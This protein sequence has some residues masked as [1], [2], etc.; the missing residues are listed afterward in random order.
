MAPLPQAARRAVIVTIGIMLI[1]VLALSASRWSHRPAQ[2]PPTPHAHSVDLKWNASVSPVVGYNVYRSE[3]GGEPYIK[4]TSAP[5][6]TTN[7]TDRTVQ[8]GRL[9]FYVVT[10]VD[11]KGKESGYSNQ[12]KA[13]IPSP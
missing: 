10:A 13:P 2:G 3:R 5:V 4:L 7:Y 6:R 9:Y 12:I 8:S 11:S 1:V